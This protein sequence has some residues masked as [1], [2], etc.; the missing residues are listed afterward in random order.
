MYS[1]YA[2]FS[3]APNDTNHTLEEE[4]HLRVL[5]QMKMTPERSKVKFCAKT[6]E[7]KVCGDYSNGRTMAAVRLRPGTYKER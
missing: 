7:C 5:D 3:D 1:E 2:I 4:E 6:S